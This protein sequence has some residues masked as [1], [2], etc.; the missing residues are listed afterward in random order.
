MTSGL[1]IKSRRVH[2]V[3]GHTLFFD[4]RAIVLFFGRKPK[5]SNFDNTVS[6][7]H[8]TIRVNLAVEQLIHVEEAVRSDDLE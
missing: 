8:D 2:F 6:K 7:D 5:I 1:I 3:V 4:D